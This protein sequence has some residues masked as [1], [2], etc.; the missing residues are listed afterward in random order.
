MSPEDRKSNSSPKSRLPLLVV[1][2]LALS[3]AGATPAA[4]TDRQSNGNDHSSSPSFSVLAAKWWQWGL[5]QPVPSPL[6]DPTGE[7][8]AEGQAGKIWFLAGGF[9]GLPDATIERSCT[10]PSGKDLFFPLLNSFSGYQVNEEPVKLAT[11]AAQR[12]VVE[13]SGIQRAENLSVLVDGCPG[14]YKFEKSVPFQ[15]TLPSD[16]L[17]GLKSNLLLKPVVDAGFYTYVPA[18]RSGKHT[19]VFTGAFPGGDTITTTYHLVVRG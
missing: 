4:A 15:V 11:V 7:R 18:L 2:L 9:N 17:F 6:T 1:V 10:V 14:K 19:V 16:N 3:L 8:C 5:A 13:S 12:D